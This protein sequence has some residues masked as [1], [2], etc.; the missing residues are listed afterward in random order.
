MPQRMLKALT[1]SAW[2]EQPT[3]IAAKHR[4]IYEPASGRQLTLDGGY[5][6]TVQEM[7]QDRRCNQSVRRSC[8]PEKTLT[9]RWGDM[10]DRQ[11]NAGAIIPSIWASSV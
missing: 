10:H 4:D 3:C 9:V 1:R 7:R 11:I 6:R 5:C 8:K 2:R